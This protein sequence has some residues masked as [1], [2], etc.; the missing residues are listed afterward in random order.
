[1]DLAF[2]AD[3]VTIAGQNRIEPAQQ[4]GKRRNRHH[5][6]SE[7]HQGHAQ[8]DFAK[9]VC[10]GVS[11]A[12]GKDQ[13]HGLF[14]V[15]QFQKREKT[16]QFGRLIG[17]GVKFFEPVEAMQPFQITGTDSAGTVVDHHRFNGLFHTSILTSMS[18]AG[19]VHGDGY[20]VTQ[21]GST[22]AQ[23]STRRSLPLPLSFHESFPGSES[24]GQCS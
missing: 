14:A 8:K 5:G 18:A 1:M 10:A 9:G 17:D 22:H 13:I 16:E 6:A 24:R 4:P 12:A 3:A 15:F 7:K 23:N 20:R 21:R 2:A 19:G 11:P